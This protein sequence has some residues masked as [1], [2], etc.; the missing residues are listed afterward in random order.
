MQW[1]G[2]PPLRELPTFHWVLAEM[3]VH[4][5][6]EEA[7]FYYSHR[8][9]YYNVKNSRY[10]DCLLITKFMLWFCLAPIL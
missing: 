9:Y 10:V 2:S 6:L 7:G 4:I 8:Y 1:R 5:L 3:A